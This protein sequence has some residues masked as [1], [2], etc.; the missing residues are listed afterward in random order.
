MCKGRVATQKST[1]AQL[2]V[3]R[4]EEFREFANCVTFESLFSGL[5]S[6]SVDEVGWHTGAV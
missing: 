5:G 6:G 4:D 2:Q 3:T 1:L